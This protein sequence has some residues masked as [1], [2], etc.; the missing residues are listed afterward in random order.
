MPRKERNTHA[1]FYH[2]VCR[3]VERRNVFLESEN[4]EKFLYSFC[5]MPNHFCFFNKTIEIS[6][7]IGIVLINKRSG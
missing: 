2:I 6:V 4:F 3:G 5:L 7:V 1:G